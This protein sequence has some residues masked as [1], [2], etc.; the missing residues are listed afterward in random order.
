VLSE[1]ALTGVQQELAAAAEANANFVSADQLRL[2]AEQ[3]GLAPAQVDAVVHLYTDAQ[4]SALRT[5]LAGIAIFALVA[6]WYVRNLP[7]RADVQSAEGDAVARAD[8]GSQ[9]EPATTGS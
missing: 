8:A 7:S 2:A 1:P 3:A 6:L 5:A 4:I 9:E